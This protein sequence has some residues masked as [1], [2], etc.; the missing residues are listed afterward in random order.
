MA[1][2][3]HLEIDNMKIDLDEYQGTSEEIVLKKAKL[4]R[5]Y[6]DNPILVEDV[7]LGFNAYAGLPGPYIKDFLQK[8]KPE[9][10]Y[11]MV[12]SFKNLHL[13]LRI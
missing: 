1:D 5:T 8:L 6:T 10:L 4:A 13:D 7:S 2:V 12:N 11:K 9:G 3:T